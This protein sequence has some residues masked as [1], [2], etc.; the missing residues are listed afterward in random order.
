MSLSWTAHT[1]VDPV[2]RIGHTEGVVVLEQQT[3]VSLVGFAGFGLAL[4]GYLAAMRRE[5]RAEISGVRTDLKTE[6]DGVRTDLK[7]EINGVRTDLKTEINGVRTDLKT[8]I[9]G[10]R[11]DLNSNAARLEAQIVS[12]HADLKTDIGRVDG[13]LVA[14]ESRL[15]DI[16]IRLP[17]ALNP[18]EPTAS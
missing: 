7:T 12:S 17:A 6:I 9:N 14:L 13:R 2:D 4:M 5:L 1:L 10:V 3:W 15:H 18:A 16:A 11:T 8:E